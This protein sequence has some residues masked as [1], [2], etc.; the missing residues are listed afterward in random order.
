MA[1]RLRITRLRRHTAG[2]VSQYALVV[3]FLGYSASLPGASYFCICCVN[4][5]IVHMGEMPN[6]SL[7]SLKFQEKER[8]GEG[9]GEG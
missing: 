3:V 6:K 9:E 1:L 2:V 4:N 8:E 7:F 5:H